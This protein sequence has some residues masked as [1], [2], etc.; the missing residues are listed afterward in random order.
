MTL[1]DIFCFKKCKLSA[2]N[3]ISFNSRLIYIQKCGLTA[4]IKM[5]LTLCYSVFHSRLQSDSQAF[6][7]VGAAAGVGPIGRAAVSHRLGQSRKQQ[8]MSATMQRYLLLPQLTKSVAQRLL[9]RWALCLLL[10]Q[11]QQMLESQL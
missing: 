5:R 3:A 7:G 6:V 11:P 8:K 10:P 2:P 4:Q 9:S 1:Y